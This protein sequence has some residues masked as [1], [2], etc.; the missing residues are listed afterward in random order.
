M[1]MISV[2]P[3]FAQKYT[4]LAVTHGFHGSPHIDKQNVGPFYGLALGDFE[5]GTGGILVE[6]SARVLGKYQS[7]LRKVDAGSTVTSPIASPHLSLL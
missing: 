6:C 5:E 4:A 2:D 1:A 7:F 3:L